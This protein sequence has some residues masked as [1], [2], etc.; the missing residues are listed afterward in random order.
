MKMLKE[1][2]KKILPRSGIDNLKQ[3]QKRLAMGWIRALSKSATL[4]R[5]HYSFFS[6]AF[7]REAYAVVVGHLQHEENLSGAEPV[8]YFLRRAVHRIEKGLIMQPRRE[9]FALD[10]IGDTVDSYIAS[11]NGNVDRD[12]V[13]WAHD[14][15]AEY[16]AVT[17]EHPVINRAREKFAR[18]ERPLSSPGS[19]RNPD[20]ERVPFAADVSTS[21]VDYTAMRQLSMKRRSVRWYENRPVPREVIDKAVEV[22]VQSPSAC[23][24]QPYRFLIFD[25]AASVAQASRL[26]MGVAGFDHNFPAIVAVVG[27]LRAYPHVR[28]RHVIYI[29]GALAAMSFM[30]ALETQGV[31]SCSINWPDIPERELAASKLLKLEPDERIVMFISLGYAAEGGLVPYSQ[32]LS[33]DEARSYGQ[34]EMPAK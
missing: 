9:V 6:A 22:A 11:L 12:E 33:L 1:S 20:T 31:S 17:G 5:F 27:R 21:S 34:L 19:L 30:F 8:N 2:L 4:R 14:V 28:D 13:S 18:L 26:P 7:D 32:K 25:D 24:R 23:N 3:L 15:L 10:Y 29:D 16:F